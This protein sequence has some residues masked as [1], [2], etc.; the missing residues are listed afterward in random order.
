M[1]KKK[2]KITD[3][4]IQVANIVDDTNIGFKNPQRGRIYSVDGLAPALNCCG[5]G[6]LEP[7]IIVE[8][9][10]MCMKELKNDIQII[11][12]GTIVYPDHLGEH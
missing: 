1:V 2:L 4:V 12:A 7:K 3:K 9:K 11:Q 6:G 10:D 5:G 8:T